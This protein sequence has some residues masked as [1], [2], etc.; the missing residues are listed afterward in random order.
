[1]AKTTQSIPGIP[2]I[3]SIT[4]AAGP[5]LVDVT[6]TVPTPEIV[7]AVKQVVAQNT[8]TARLTTKGGFPIRHFNQGIVFYPG[9][10]SAEIPVDAW[11]EN[12]IKHGALVEV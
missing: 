1:M 5:E 12:Q 3:Q 4:G 7:E 10:P 6:E 9:V 8:R 2:G 11:L